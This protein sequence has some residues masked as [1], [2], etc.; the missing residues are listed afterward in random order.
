MILSVSQVDLS[1][2]G[3]SVSSS[4]R[5]LSSGRLN[6]RCMGRGVKDFHVICERDGSVFSEVQLGAPG[7]VL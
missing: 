7:V 3:Q 4:V 5:R 2:S 1:A 6:N